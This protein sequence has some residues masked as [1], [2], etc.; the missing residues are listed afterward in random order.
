MD[1]A[2]KTSSDGH[3]LAAFHFAHP[4]VLKETKPGNKHPSLKRD[5]IRRFTC[6]GCGRTHHKM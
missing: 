1:P 6:A 5:L 3:R 4:T 2:K